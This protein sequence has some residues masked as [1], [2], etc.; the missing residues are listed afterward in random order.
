MV[1]NAGFEFLENWRVC[2]RGVIDNQTSIPR[3][4]FKSG[5]Q[6]ARMYRLLLYVTMAIET[7]RRALVSGFATQR[8]RV[9]RF[10]YTEVK[11]SKKTEKCRIPCSWGMKTRVFGM[12]C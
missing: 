3:L 12:A 6:T 11:L 5:F 8:P 4:L 1:A 10:H 7:L 9:S 2:R